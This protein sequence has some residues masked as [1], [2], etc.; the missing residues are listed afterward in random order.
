MQFD[1]AYD[2][3]QLKSGNATS[4][5]R[6]PANKPNPLL[7][8]NAYG[9]DIVELTPTEINLIEAAHQQL[10]ARWFKKLYDEDQPELVWDKFAA[11]A[12]ERFAELGFAI[13]IEWM[14][15]KG[16][17]PDLPGT[18]AVPKISVE[19]RLEKTEPDLDLIQREIREGKLDGKKGVIREDGRWEEEERKKQL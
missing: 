7:Q 10:Q 4:A 16:D 12:R 13:D 17:T 3:S 19:A 14:E 5:S 2:L 15:V 11:E 8:G 6:R 9:H 18:A 1:G